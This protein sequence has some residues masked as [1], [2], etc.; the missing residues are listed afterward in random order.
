[1]QFNHL[2]LAL[3][4]LNFISN[5]NS[6][7]TDSTNVNKN[8][9]HLQAGGVGGYGSL[10][11]ERLF[12]L[13][14]DFSIGGRIGLST[15]RI[16]DYTTQFNPDLLIPMS[17]KLLFGKEHKVL[18]GAGQLFSNTVNASQLTGQPKRETHFHT[19]LLIGYRY[20]KK[21]AK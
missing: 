16:N 5:G 11:Y 9:L 4:L 17:L 15:L 12:P 2:L 19:H 10:N 6:Q 14:N 21:M 3:F 1:M 13:K 7:E 18:I 20:Q 8:F